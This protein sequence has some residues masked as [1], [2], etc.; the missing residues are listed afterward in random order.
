MRPNGKATVADEHEAMDLVLSTENDAEL[1]GHGNT[2]GESIRKNL[3][4]KRK[5]GTLNPDLAPKLFEYLMEA[6]A[7]KYRR[8]GGVYNA[9]TR[10]AAAYAIAHQFLEQ[11]EDG[12]WD[13]MQ[14]NGSLQS[15]CH[16]TP[17]FKKFKDD[18]GYELKKAFKSG[19]KLTIS[20]VRMDSGGYAPDHHRYFGGHLPGRILYL[21][22]GPYDSVIVRAPDKEFLRGALKHIIG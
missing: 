8:H 14:P 11:V 2:Q 12:E 22:T 18:F 3:L 20:K 15:N 7:K 16:T 9:A 17:E 6:A 1:W 21:V 10:R 5:K 19:E 13:H 4:L